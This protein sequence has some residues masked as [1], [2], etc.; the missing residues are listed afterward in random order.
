MIADLLRDDLAPVTVP[1]SVQVP[2]LMAVESFATV[3]QLVTTVTGQLLPG[4]PVTDALAAV[5]PGGSMTGA[6]KLASLAALDEL[7][8]G[9]RGIYSGAMGWVGDNNT[10]ELSVVIRTMV[11]DDGHL[12]IGA[13]G[14]VVVGSDP[15]A[16]NQEK[17][18]KAQALI[19][20]IAEELQ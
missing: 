11:L 16:E 13:G 18:L 6:P 4:T 7:E 10:A 2:K 3:H 15:A 5:F 17:L 9:P 14:A 1:G 8:A 19:D 20:C 12:S